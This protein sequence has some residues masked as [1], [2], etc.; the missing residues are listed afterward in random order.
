MPLPANHTFSKSA[1]LA[2]VKVKYDSKE[3][4]NLRR[5]HTQK[6]LADGCKFAGQQCKRPNRN[7]EL[8]EPINNSYKEVLVI[9][10]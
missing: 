2:S 4:E 5:I 6:N 1:S 3:H 7:A 9:V 8:N 10:D